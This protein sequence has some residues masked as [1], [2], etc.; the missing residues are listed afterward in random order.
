M[1]YI[2]LLSVI[3]V[4][5][6]SALE[7]NVY[8][9]VLAMGAASGC[10]DVDDSCTITSLPYEE[11]FDSCAAFIGSFPPCWQRM[12]IS[13]S[14]NP[15]GI[16]LQT[17]G[18]DTVLAFEYHTQEKQYVALPKVDGALLANHRLY[19]DLKYQY[20]NTSDQSATIV[21]AMTNPLD[22]ST[23]R[24]IQYLRP[25]PLKRMTM[26][27]SS[28]S[29]NE[30]IVVR[31]Q[32]STSHSF[33][34]KSVAIRELSDYGLV[35]N[36]RRTKI[37][38]TAM[39]LEWDY[40]PGIDNGE[41]LFRVKAY[42]SGQTS[43]LA[44]IV[45]S[46]RIALMN[47]F[48]AAH[49]PYRLTIEPL[50][51]DGADTLSGGVQDS[52][53]FYASYP[54]GCPSPLA[55]LTEIDDDSVTV[56]WV[57]QDTNTLW[58]IQ[59]QPV[60]SPQQPWQVIATN[61]T[62][63]RYRL[64][65]F[66]AGQQYKI[67]VTSPCS[68]ILQLNT[69][70]YA[71]PCPPYVTIPFEED[72]D[73]FN[74]Y[75][76]LSTSLGSY[77]SSSHGN[78]FLNMSLS[79]FHVAMPR[80]NVPL[81]SLT[82]S[83]LIYVNSS[84]TGSGLVAGVLPEGGV[85]PTDFVAIDTI[86]TTHSSWEQFVVDYSGCPYPNGRIAFKRFGNAPVNLDNLRVDYPPSCQ[87]PT[88]IVDSVVTTHSAQITWRPVAGALGYEVEYGPHGFA[89]GTGSTVSVVTNHATLTG[90]NPSSHYDYYVRTFCA[91]RD[92]SLWTI[93]MSIVTDCGDIS[94]L[95]YVEDLSAWDEGTWSGCWITNFSSFP[96]L[97]VG[98][99]T[100]PDRREVKSLVL[101]NGNYSGIV[102]LPRLGRVF[103]AQY[104]Q[105]TFTVWMR[106]Y[107]SYYYNP[108]GSNPSD[109]METPAIEVGVG[110]YGASTYGYTPIDT[111]PLTYFP[112]TH[113]VSFANYTDSGRYIC[114]R[115]LDNDHYSAFLNY[116][117][118][119][120]ASYC[121]H[122][123]RLSTTAV[124][125]T[126]AQLSWRDQ[127][128]A[129]EWLI[130]VG[131][132]G[133]LD[134]SATVIVTN[135][136]PYL[137]TGLQAGK[138]YEWRV[139]SI[140]SAADSSGWSLQSATFQ[141]QP[142]AAPVPYSCDFDDPAEAHRWLTQSYHSGAVEMG[143][144]HG[145]LNDGS[146]SMGYTMLLDSNTTANH[147]FRQGY[148][149][150]N[151]LIYR[152]VD[153]GS[154]D[155]LR[156]RYTISFRARGIT[157]NYS[158]GVMKVYLAN[159]EEIPL[160]TFNYLATPWENDSLYLL[161]DHV[162]D[163]SWQTYSI[164][165]DTLS[166][167]KRLVFYATSYYYYHNEQPVMFQID[168]V[169]IYQNECPR[170]FDLRTTHV[171]DSM[172]Q[173][174]WYGSS[175]E[176]YVVHW[177]DA[178][179]A[180]NPSHTLHCDT[181][182]T[183]QI[184][185]TGLLPNNRYGIQ[186]QQICPGGVL[187]SMSEPYI[188]STLLCDSLRCDSALAPSLLASESTILPVSLNHQFSYS[189]QIYP[190]SQFGGAGIIHAINLR[191]NLTAPDS[192]ENNYFV[193]I[194]HTD[195][196]AFA[197]AN[198][199]V[200]PEALSIVHAG[201][202][203]QGEGWHKIVFEAP[204]HYN[205]TDNLVLA[206]FSNSNTAKPIGN[207]M[208]STSLQTTIEVRGNTSMDYPTLDALNRYGGSRNIFPLRSQATFDF[209]PQCQCIQPQLLSPQLHYNWV[210]LHWHQDVAE[211]HEISYRPLS[212]R[213]WS[214]VIT[215]TDSCLSLTGI[216]PG[217]PYIYRVRNACPEYPERNWS[218]GM[219][220]TSQTI[221]PAPENFHL[222]NLTP[223]EVSF[224]WTLDTALHTY[225]IH[226]FNTIYDSTITTS[227]DTAT[228]YNLLHGVTYRAAI[229]ATCGTMETGG[230]WSDTIEFTTPTCP[231]ATDLTY[232]SIGSHSIDLDWVSDSMAQEWE[233]IYG[234]VGFALDYGTSVFATHHPY[235]LT[236]LEAET[237]YEAFV[238]AY[239]GTGFF[240]EQWSNRIIFTTH[241][242]GIA[243]AHHQ[244]TFTVSPNPARGQFVVTFADHNIRSAQIV[245]RDV[246]G[247]IV[248]EQRSDGQPLKFAHCRP[249]VYYITVITDTWSD[250]RKIIVE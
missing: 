240:S 41:E 155:S 207:L 222:A 198:D 193:Y 62:G 202:L 94:Q 83:G 21:G 218:Y 189:Q 105:A 126:Q 244:P 173:L 139:Q 42:A 86:V 167:I 74:N 84:V 127:S 186:V 120:M 61:V 231:D 34:I 143:W 24:P 115:L 234:S 196:T 3:V 238:R 162:G 239:C 122:P 169:E 66:E 248:S 150:V 170:P 123:D 146:G 37:G 209:C 152:D 22:S 27:L 212:S 223:Y 130:E 164:D 174:T 203:P 201:P 131:P 67:A 56:E 148:L 35:T 60:M 64:G 217:M 19:L 137:L 184:A 190:A 144:S 153:F 38:I 88:Q 68:A 58:S 11:T 45:T 48:D 28:F 138:E 113:E 133:H 195:K 179:T 23:F 85:L 140:C 225:Y 129:S 26:S 163:S 224:R 227:G 18:N 157:T 116:A 6:L 149:F 78:W 51:I 154:T 29:T 134:D 14:Y 236:G 168:D 103:R 90:L 199:Y 215:T 135:N 44:T 247:S 220:Q 72:F 55:V 197:N 111:L 101:G 47:G 182:S 188:F 20:V 1:K 141:T 166:G 108:Y 211:R 228:F 91:N 158:T 125:N 192:A 16:F 9:N 121:I 63:T 31:S 181:V 40:L 5:Y 4:I 65:G 219:F 30:Y 82:L 95:P 106:Q 178:D 99:V 117:M 151:S 175:A 177:G 54:Y 232:S 226:L 128:E 132:R 233:I 75:C 187:S 79:S 241:S 10:A 71:T 102:C 8:C 191:Y 147:P 36:F 119:D 15:N 156:R 229:Q 221:C 57:G 46:R 180:T 12:Y 100:L 70:N 142:F 49:N 53:I 17:V 50:L 176:Q 205:G 77:T 32:L 114:L 145:A 13:S 80:F 118:I 183:N 81:D 39:V 208:A 160:N 136:N 112:T 2:K 69:V 59:L 185:L 159:P 213:T 245:L 52:I 214:Q 89:H 172:A 243:S 7:N 165:L 246:R 206:I 210:R 76:W 110:I 104:L 235:T 96:Y 204:F 124:G 200:D 93:P 107:Q 161:A 87:L 249:G 25:N 33:H 109:P 230:Y 194:G 250:T 171:T 237:E 98:Y 73:R 216:V 43:P 92:T 242:A 97:G